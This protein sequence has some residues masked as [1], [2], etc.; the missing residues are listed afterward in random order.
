[1][2]VPTLIYWPSSI[3]KDAWMVFT[4]GIASYG[5]ACLF[6]HRL[7]RGFTA[8]TIGFAGMC[9]V[10]PHIALVVCGGLILAVLVRRNRGSG[11]RIMSILFVILATFVVVKV[12]SSFFG[13]QAFNRTSI[14]AQ[15]NDTSA[16]TG[17]GGSAFSPVTVNS[18]IDFPLAAVTVLYRPFPFEAHS[19]QELIT[20]IEGVVLA[21]L[22]LRAARRS[23]QALRRSGD[24]PY[25]M[26]ALGAMLVFIVAFSGFS[27]FGLL[28]R[29]RAVIQPLFFV[30]LTLPEN[31]DAEFPK[32]KRERARGPRLPPVT[33]AT[34][35]PPMGPYA[36]LGLRFAVRVDDP[37]IAARIAALYAACCTADPRPPDL[38]LTVHSDAE[39][40]TFELRVGGEH[41]CVTTDADELLAWVVWRVN[42]AAVHHDDDR[43]VLHAAAVAIGE[44]TVLLA[45]PS[46]AG[47]ST[48][49]TALVL[50]G[51]A[52]MSDDSVAFDH[53][54]GRVVSNPKPIS[55]DAG[56]VAALERLVGV[57]RRA[58]HDVRTR[59]AAG[60]RRGDTSRR[61]ARPGARGAPVLP[62]GRAPA[63]RAAPA[64]RRRRVARRPV[65]QLRA[66]RPGRAR[67]GR[68]HRADDARHRARIRRPRRRGRD[69]HRRARV[70]DA[71][72]VSTRVVPSTGSVP[73]SR[74]RS[75]TV[76]RS[77]GTSPPRRCTA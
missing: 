6:T 36:S 52:Y 28:A 75:S 3:G 27:N 74:S 70:S 14:Q 56:A 4:M 23:W 38:E 35:G 21:L 26:Y 24:Y 62:R 51:G 63:R 40:A 9:M 43:L 32:W 57:A 47:K 33:S 49:A 34:L 5:A 67:R 72:V 2:L 42:D 69:D 37:A 64:G 55:L 61:R 66:A 16:I 44:H 8:I 30:F 45:G 77:S 46:G 58:A 48:L 59:G 20:S 29:E 73:A 68:V 1:M 65:V 50:G 39:A 11:S 17:Q 13:I 15:I 76:R 19:V 22:T 53:D 60:D 71:R 10:R 25:F 31:I 54:T 41:C 12:A 18:P 7:P